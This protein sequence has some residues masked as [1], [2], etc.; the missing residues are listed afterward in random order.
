MRMPLHR[1]VLFAALAAALTSTGCA[2]PIPDGGFDAPDPASRIYAAVRVA[3]EFQRT[4]IRPDRTTLEALV[5]MLSSA[6]P[7]A[8]F[9]ASQTLREIAGTDFGFHPAA[10]LAE[11]LPAIDRW[12][13]WVEALPAATGAH[14]S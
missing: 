11:R 5:I 8:R 2:P 9:V 3:A 14:S 12:R 1:H 10:P 4:G 6:D 7:A 13:A